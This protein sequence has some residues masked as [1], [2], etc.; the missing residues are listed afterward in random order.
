[1]REDPAGMGVFGL[2]GRDIIIRS[3]SRAERQGW[4]AH[5]PDSAWESSRSIAISAD[6]IDRGTAIAVRLPEEWSVKLAETCRE[7]A[8]QYSVSVTFD[9][10][11]DPR[12]HQRRIGG[13]ARTGEPWRL[14]SD[15]YAGQIAPSAQ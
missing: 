12:A 2:A 4:I 7:V 9:G 1:M 11:A 13:R 15:H 3:W 10:E 5:N 6:P 14:T 8:C